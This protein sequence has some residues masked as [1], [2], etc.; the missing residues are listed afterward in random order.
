MYIERSIYEGEHVDALQQAVAEHQKQFWDERKANGGQSSLGYVSLAKLAGEGEL[1]VSGDAW[2]R[3][4]L[5]EESMEHR[6]IEEMAIPPRATGSKH[7]LATEKLNSQMRRQL[8]A[9]EVGAIL[10]YDDQVSALDLHERAR[11]IMA[12]SRAA[13]LA[14]SAEA[15]PARPTAVNGSSSSTRRRTAKAGAGTA[16]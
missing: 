1:F 16:A 9:G 8:L 15:E 12:Q 5:V 2:L 7:A 4:A 14:I 13:A 6:L 3:G 10:L 11:T